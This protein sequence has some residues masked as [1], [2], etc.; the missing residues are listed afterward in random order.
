LA[1]WVSILK[2]KQM[3]KNNI[4]YISLTGM[5]E[6]LGRSQVLEYLIDLSKENKIYLI[7]F[8]REDDLSSVDEIKELITD[9]NIEWHYKVYSNKYGVVSTVGQIVQSIRLGSK[10]I[11]EH[12]IDI[13]HARSMIPATMGLLL[14]KIHGVKLL[15]DIRGFAIDEKVDSR[16][17]NKSSLLYKVLKK[18]D[19]HL[20]KA[21]DH[22]VTLTHVAKE[23]LHEK[24]DIPYEKT[25]VIPTCASKEVFKRLT[26]A[27]IEIFKSSL[28]Y[29][30][31]DTIIIHT[32]TVSGWYDFDSELA[33][34]KA[35]MIED[36]D[37][38][39][40]VLN[41]S[42]QPF[43]QQMFDKDEM[44]EERVAIS[45]SSFDEVHKYLNIADASLFLIKP[46][47]SKQASA[48]TKF[49][50][51]VACRLPSI[52]NGNVG[53]M[54]FYLDRYDVGTVINVDTLDEE[55]EVVAKELLDHMKNSVVKED[56][57]KTLFDEHFDKNMAVR[58]Y[59]TI[60]EKLTNA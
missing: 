2:V 54:G 28:G 57:Y 12:S 50:E 22:I 29:K 17:L 15:F 13:V 18:L 33:L 44:P 55:L 49:A 7:S 16:R 38:H 39:F 30:K 43:I 27:E 51:N 24:L 19:N 6:P 45:S 53:D 25:T 41:K 10:L 36:E 4:L 31:E 52:T 37:V 8:E 3:H 60:Y 59:Q 9:Y 21:S 58:K 26:S 40:L 14:K 23:I 1:F 34:V 11:K 32:G 5:T 46:S 20:Y 35:M 56:E 48:P 42:E 47:Y